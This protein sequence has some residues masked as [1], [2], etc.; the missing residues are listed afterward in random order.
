M[1]AHYND[2]GTDV[3]KRGGLAFEIKADDSTLEVNGIWKGQRHRLVDVD[4]TDIEGGKKFEISDFFF[5]QNNS[6]SPYYKEASTIAKEHDRTL[7]GIAM[8]IIKDKMA[9]GD[10]LREDTDAWF[11]RN[12]ES[13]IDSGNLKRAAQMLLDETAG[14]DVAKEYLKMRYQRLF[15]AGKISREDFLRN[16]QSRGWYGAWL[17]HAF[18]P[19]KDVITTAAF[20]SSV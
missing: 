1:S 17:P 12:G 16:I 15:P 6:T 14:E 5:W 7:A 13:K 20:I 9:D 10:Y 19:K 8:E 4:I 3:V 11:G 2:H 18:T